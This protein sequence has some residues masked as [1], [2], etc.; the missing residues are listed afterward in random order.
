[1]FQKWFG[2]GGFETDEAARLRQRRMRQGAL[3]TEPRLGPQKLKAA[4][5]EHLLR[6]ASF[7]LMHVFQTQPKVIDRRGQFGIDSALGN[8]DEQKL[9]MPNGLGSHMEISRMHSP[10]SSR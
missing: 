2:R 7:R 9:T 5:L 3:P 10:S 4:P 8:A 6:G 1:I